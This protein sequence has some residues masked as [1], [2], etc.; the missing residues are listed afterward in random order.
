M[1][2]KLNQSFL[3]TYNDQ[4]YKHTAMVNH[5][6]TV[7]SF[8]MDD[9]R[10]IYYTVLDIGKED[11]QKGPLDVNYWIDNPQ[12][13]LFPREIE[14]VG[15]AVVN[16]VSMPVV[17]QGTRQEVS[18][19]TTVSSSEQDA[20]LSSTAR[21]TADAPF[22]VFS[23]GQHIYVFRQSLAGDHSDMV[24][25]LKS[26]GSSGA[27]TDLTQ[28]V[29]D[30]KVP[31]VTETLLVDRYILAGTVLKSSREV[32]FRRSEN[33]TT[34]ASGKDSLGAKDMEGNA[35]YET[36]KELDFIRN[37]SNGCF[38]VIL[39]PTEIADIER[40]QI[41]AYNKLS[42]SVDS[43][44]IERDNEGFFNLQGTRLYTSPDSQYKAS[45]LERKPGSCPFTGRALVP[46]D[47]LDVQTVSS[48]GY[49]RKALQFDGTSHHHVKIDNKPELQ[50]TGNQTLEMW[51]KPAALGRGQ[52]PFHKAYGG[53]G[54][55]TLRID[56]TLSYFYG[57]A[58]TSGPPYD[59]FK[60]SV[61][62]SAGQWVH[63]AIVRDLANLKLQ[64]YING[65][66]SGD[67]V[68]AFAQ[69]TKGNDPVLIGDGYAGSFEGLIDEV[70]VWNR[71]RSHAEIT[72]TMNHRLIGDE[73]GLAGYWRFDEATGNAINDLSIY[74]NHGTLT[75]AQ[76]VDSDAPI[77]PAIQS[78][79]GMQYS[80][81]VFRDREVE[82]G[83]AARLY[84]EQEK[85][86][87]VT[88]AKSVKQNARVL[89]TAAI[90]GNIYNPTVSSSANKVLQF[91]GSDGHVAVDNSPALQITGDQTIEMWIKPT[92]LGGKRQNPFDKA[93]AGEGSITLEPNGTLNYYYGTFGGAGDPFTHISSETKIVIDDWTHIAIVR[94]LTNR[95]LHWYINGIESGRMVAEFAAAKKGT[96]SVFIGNG[97]AGRFTG[98][99]DEVRLWNRARSQVEIR[100]AMNQRLIGDESGLA[101]Y[102]R[103]DE[104]TGNVI[105]DSSPNGSHGTLVGSGV[106]RIGF[107]ETISSK[108][109]IAAVDLGVSRAGKLA[110]M[111]DTIPLPHLTSG[112]SVNSEGILNEISGLETDI[113]RLKTNIATLNTEISALVSSINGYENEVTDIQNIETQIAQL[114]SNISSYEKPRTVT[115]YQRSSTD[116]RGRGKS[117]EMKTNEDKWWVGKWWN[118]SIS[119]IGWEK[120]VKIECY[121]HKSFGGTKWTFPGN[122]EGWNDRIT[123]IK[124]F[125]S[126]ELQEDI[127]DASSQI[128]TKNKELARL[129]VIRDTTLPSLR[130]QRGQKNAL[131]SDKQG[132]LFTKQARLI[133]LRD[134]RIGTPPPQPMIPFHSDPRGLT[135][136]SG[137]LGFAHSDS[138]PYLFES[139]L[140]RMALYFKGVNNQFFSAYYDVNTARAHWSLA[141]ASGS[142]TLI[143]RTTDS[144][145]NATRIVVTNGSDADHCAVILSNDQTGLTENWGDVPREAGVFTQVLNGQAGD[146]IFVG[147]LKNNL[148]GEAITTLDL[149]DGLPCEAPA[150][151]TLLLEADGLI[152]KLTVSSK[153]N[154]GAKSISI[155]SV[156]LTTLDTDTKVYLLRYDYA[157]KAIS[158]RPGD[159]LN[160]GNLQLNI[161]VG[162][163]TGKVNNATANR[164]TE[165]QSP[166]W[167]ADAP[168]SALY[169]DGENDHLAGQQ[170]Q[171]FRHK[172]DIT[173]EAWVRPLVD[174]TTEKDIRLIH[175]NSGHSRYIL[176][177]QLK[178]DLHSALSLDGNDDF[179]T[180]PSASKLGM[181][182]RDFTVEAWVKIDPGAKNSEQPIL[183]NREVAFNKTLHLVIRNGKPY[184]GF[185]GNDLADPTVLSKGTWYHLAFR[186]TAASKQ[187][188]I[189]VNG[190]LT[191]ERI[192]PAHYQGTDKLHIGSTF[193]S[194]YLHG[195]ID[196]VR[197]WSIPRSASD[198]KATLSR[199]LSEQEPGLTA[200]YYFENG[201]ANDRSGNGHHGILRGNLISR[202]PVVSALKTYH[203][204]A[205]VGN[206]GILSKTP[207]VA[208]SWHHFAAVYNQ[209]YA[210]RFNGND[211]A[212]AGNNAM[213]NITEN[214]TIEAFVKLDSLG[215]KQGILSKGI[216]DNGGE[217][218][219]PYAFY[220]NEN[221]KLVLEFEGEDGANHR[222]A[223]SAGVVAGAFTRVAVVRKTGREKI[224]K[225]ANRDITY[226]DENGEKT[227]KRMTIIE[228]IDFKTYN[229]IHFYID[230][231]P[232]NSTGKHTGKNPMGNNDSLFIGQSF[233]AAQEQTQ[234]QGTISEIRIWNVARLPEE[235]NNNLTGSEGGLTAWWR[236]EENTGNIAYDTKGGNHARIS[237]TRWVNTPDPQGS[238]FVLYR[239]G[240]EVDC[241]TYIPRSTGN[242]A[243]FIVGARQRD[244]GSYTN[245]YK[246]DLEEVRIWKTARRKEE[247]LD[248]LFTRLKGE[249]KDLIAN[250]SFDDMTATE[251]KDSGLKSNHLTLPSSTN[252][253]PR[254]VLSTA[255][256]STDAAQIRS[257]LAGIKTDF[258]EQISGRPA[259]AEYADMQRLEDGSLIGVHKRCYAYTREGKWLLSTGYKVG[260]LVT[261]WIGQ[262]QFDPQVTGYIEGAP[263]VPSENLT[264]GYY[265]TT[266]TFNGSSEVTINESESVNYSISTSKESG[267]NSAFELEA[268]L[269]LKFDPRIILAPLGIG[270]SKKISFGFQSKFK[271]GMEA[272][273][274]W[275]SGESFGSGQNVTRKMSA[276]IGGSWDVPDKTQ[277]TN[278]ALTR[279]FIPANMGFAFVESETADIYALRLEHNGA[280]VAFR[281]LPT[282]DIPRDTNIIPFPIN[283]R[284]SKQG[285]L[286]GRIGYGSNGGIVLD[287]DYQ[288]AISYGEYSYFKPKEAYE[289]KKRIER[290][291]QRLKNYYDSFNTEPAGARSMGALAGIMGGAVA[292]STLLGAAAGAKAGALA[293]GPAI[294]PIMAGSMIAG[295]M[296]ATIGSLIDATKNK[297]ENLPK[298][299]A[300]RNIAN[301]YVWTADGGFYEESTEIS[302]V[303]SESKSGSYSFKGKLDGGFALNIDSGVKSDFGLKGMLGGSLNLTKSKS[304]DA[305]NSF[306][307][308]MK[309]LVPNNLQRYEYTNA[310]EQAGTKET[311]SGV[312]GVY[313]KNNNPVNQPGKVDAYRFMTFHLEPG[314]NNFEDLFGKVIDPIWLEESQHPNAIAL[315][316]ANQVSKKPKCWRVFHRVTFV[317]R[318]L[319]DFPSSTAPSLETK[320]KDLNIASNYELVRRLDPFVRD[321]TAN[322]TQFKDAVT[323]AVQAYLP[324]L[325]TEQELSQITLFLADY[326]GVTT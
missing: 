114:L 107:E 60:S 312:K 293:L 198:I 311:A 135:V 106:T 229:D 122:S 71:A 55:I 85:Q 130:T 89:L 123:S 76:R 10:R 287:S 14:Q 275:G 290:E 111:P 158:N 258:H 96:S 303:S 79:S 84:Y 222:Y 208:N 7:V 166:Q 221:G 54:S 69:A 127:D 118:D 35:F 22:Q 203:C 295:G 160:N 98:L 309:L 63:I 8:A 199:R 305:K 131:R 48:A 88:D 16:P 326:Y 112:E 165:A 104:T 202:D 186:Y 142:L 50:I 252:Q 49:A 155:N 33:R 244:N 124:V 215:R 210:L 67:T 29:T 90:K 274:A 223:S 224:E 173:L 292:G 145:V 308:S 175:C 314:I 267:F 251:V 45:V 101:G 302:E 18:A 161:V 180:L 44:N 268:N 113:P 97:Y 80:S 128:T 132:S 254:Q 282:P 220:I 31:L 266:Q 230:S 74:G 278:P 102:W 125:R 184:M 315:R 277:W 30:Q 75:G 191:S 70:R 288:T 300:R 299:Y 321:H 265:R 322:F 83:L 245:H 304:E 47:A 248:N 231:V 236:F 181:T 197:I 178:Q 285:T 23:D 120:G 207:I 172:G 81:F 56:G 218:S 241:T 264:E 78:D 119:G 154:S 121:E 51:I 263:P 189:F 188:A 77:G 260:N 136:S 25:K 310:D 201:N 105:N 38:S 12:L 291:V 36:T 141:T 238:R 243:Q 225:T 272:N 17:K 232:D 246:G 193:G 169:F 146:K 13:L 151:S 217:G 27:E 320:M 214:L 117:F 99:I 40:W 11:Q 116:K 316:E 212:D 110:Q 185:H 289:L 206:D 176:G 262:A 273:G 226:K 284:Y 150:G 82:A 306:S 298:K 153:A 213:L 95:T 9:Q 68:A 152:S 42:K 294:A 219:V 64:W 204:F 256:I 6:G 182:N 255:P 26:G 323:M 247:I 259:A 53:E 61:V 21:L 280:L 144:R 195:D 59:E 239:D 250:Y 319:P 318:I 24:Y 108:K 325:S 3:K 43:F 103:F 87:S 233:I 139:A 28:F 1:D 209:S 32:R 164:T 187:Q 279:R 167:V 168:G 129:R 307:I 190:D 86:S 41:F 269:G 137:L 92:V 65:V 93:Y 109:Y 324:E 73:F 159:T 100:Q 149:K 133:V 276:A 196:E 177:L 39:L 296:G 19:E 313:D 15:F 66:K 257:A 240:Q 216:M 228:S 115:F 156:T 192:A 4:Q 72:Q 148:M 170:H 57:T 34:P 20:F 200:Y 138:P 205:S 134:M 2:N 281:M 317:S 126:D 37:L 261:E 297:D 235:I 46:N 271:L 174:T 5:R 140:G 227:T 249:K 194:Y 91:D 157:S 211:Y 283:N 286:D 162:T 94:D 147:K 143:S 58:G 179:V 242:K 171:H 237:G 253:Q 234:F 62:I 183:G 301:T 270:M 163:A 52:N